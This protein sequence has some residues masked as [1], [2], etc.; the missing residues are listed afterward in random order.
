MQFRLVLV[1]RRLIK[2]PATGIIFDKEKYFIPLFSPAGFGVHPN[3]LSNRFLKKPV[4]DAINFQ[5]RLAFHIHLFYTLPL[6][7]T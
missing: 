5:V 4:K 6:C 2:E 1:F 3:S 7:G